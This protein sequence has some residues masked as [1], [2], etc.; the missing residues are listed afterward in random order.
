MSR[1]FLVAFLFH[2]FKGMERSLQSILF[3][4][5]FEKKLEG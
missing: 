2:I 1:R 5:E 3:D 4:L